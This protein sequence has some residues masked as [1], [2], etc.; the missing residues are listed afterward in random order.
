MLRRASLDNVHQ[1]FGSQFRVCFLP[2]NGMYRLYWIKLDTTE[3][4]MKSNKAIFS[5]QQLDFRSFYIYIFGSLIHL[6]LVPGT[7]R[8]SLQMFFKLFKRWLITSTYSLSEGSESIWRPSDW[9][10]DFAIKTSI[11]SSTL[12][13]ITTLPCGVRLLRRTTPCSVT[14]VWRFGEIYCL[15][16]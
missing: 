16:F 2:C 11:L 9:K 14:T 13:G 1:Y 4:H 3:C 15:H 5:L 8:Q 12:K 6:L 10:S 7:E